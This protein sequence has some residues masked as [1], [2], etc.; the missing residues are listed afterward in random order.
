[1]NQ[2]IIITLGIGLA[3]GAII[4]TV[5]SNKNKKENSNFSSACGACG[6]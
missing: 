1:M 4:Y 2:K 3:I 5:V 6:G